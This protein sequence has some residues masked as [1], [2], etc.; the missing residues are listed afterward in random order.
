[1]YSTNVLMKGKKFLFKF[2]QRE[3]GKDGK[4][5]RE[6]G[7]SDGDYPTVIS[8]APILEEDPIGPTFELKGSK[9][10][11][12]GKKEGRQREGGA[13]E[14]KEVVIFEVRED[15]K[16]WVYKNLLLEHH[17]IAGYVLKIS[18][19][20]LYIGGVRVK[21]EW[22]GLDIIVC[23]TKH[24]LALFDLLD[25]LLPGHRVLFGSIATPEPLC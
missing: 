8:Y 11:R 24:L 14:Q 9:E 18:P 6:K 22:E 2:F 13:K 4:E 10:G 3:G 19:L 23:S 20:C 1:M 16:S 5:G 7:K 12:K 15:G 21:E 17:G 25:Y